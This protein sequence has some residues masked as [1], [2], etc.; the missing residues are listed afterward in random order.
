MTI[1]GTTGN[2]GAGSQIRLRGIT[3]A[4]MGNQPLIY[5]DGVR[6]RSEGYGAAPGGSRSANVTLSTLDDINPADIER[7]EIIKGP[8]A[9]TL[10]GTEAA[11][12]VIQIFTK[13]G[14]KRA[15]DLDIRDAAGVKSA[16]GVGS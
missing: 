6:M 4:S 8:A 2:P 14:L 11:A 13:R 10:Y 3:S 5:V 16:E 12:G 15:S 9:T 1:R 7:V